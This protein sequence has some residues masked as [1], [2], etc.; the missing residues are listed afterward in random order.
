LATLTAANSTRTWGRAGETDD[1]ASQKYAF[2][3]IVDSAKT[4]RELD[5]K[6]SLFFWYNY[7]GPLGKLFRSMASTY[8]W[9]YRLQSEAFPD[10]GPKVPPVGRRIVIL[11]TDSGS[12]VKK[13]TA[14]LQNHALSSQVRSNRTLHEGPFT[15]EMT[16]IEI[17]PAATTLSSP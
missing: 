7:D 3:S 11:S 8:G 9:S 1:P 13:A 2:L 17:V 15:W 16:E 6:A 12:M 14:V 4:I 10:L 5:P